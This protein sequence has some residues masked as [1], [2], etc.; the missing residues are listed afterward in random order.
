MPLAIQADPLDTIA[1]HAHHTGA[2]IVARIG[3]LEAIVTLELQLAAAIARKTGAAQSHT[4]IQKLDIGVH[5]GPAPNGDGL[6]TDLHASVPIPTHDTKHRQQEYFP[7]HCP[8][9]SGLLTGVRNNAATCFLGDERTGVGEL[10]VRG[11]SLGT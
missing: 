3:K 4:F 10:S 6:F 1:E 7:A 5:T 9:E 2:A 11:A 8:E